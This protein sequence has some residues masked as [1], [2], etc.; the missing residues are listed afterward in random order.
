MQADLPPAPP[1]IVIASRPHR[2]RSHRPELKF[3][4]VTG[5]VE[6]LMPDLNK[7]YG[8]QRFMFHADGGSP[9]EL[10]VDND[11]TFGHRVP[12]LK[13]G[14]KLTIR[15]VLYHD[16]PRGNRPARDGIHWTHH[17]SNQGDAG[18]I[19]TPDGATFE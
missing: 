2:G 18:Y 11:L 4:V 1:A 6:K 8:H 9:A 13:V 17:R 7:G 10:E 19:K 14:E 12:D 3:V 15:G 5:S 16:A